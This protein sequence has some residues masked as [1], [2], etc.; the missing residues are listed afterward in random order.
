MYIQSEYVWFMSNCLKIGEKNVLNFKEHSVHYCCHKIRRIRQQFWQ[1][2]C[3]GS[4]MIEFL[5]IFFSNFSSFRRNVC[6]SAPL[7]LIWLCVFCEFYELKIIWINIELD[8]S[9]NVNFRPGQFVDQLNNKNWMFLVNNVIQCGG[10]CDFLKKNCI[11]LLI[12]Q[13]KEIRCR[14]YPLRIWPKAIKCV[15]CVSEISLRLCVVH[16]HW[17]RDSRVDNKAYS[18]TRLNGTKFAANFELFLETWCLPI[19]MANKLLLCT[20]LWWFGKW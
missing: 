6:S 18:N 11:S 5:R 7:K 14:R 19:R 17:F 15:W 3:Y 1:Q 8:R 13:H 4:T 9:G 2:F 20:H 10:K 16:D 12:T